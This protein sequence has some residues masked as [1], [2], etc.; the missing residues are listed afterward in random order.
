MFVVLMNAHPR[1]LV[2]SAAEDIFT[3]LPAR[4]KEATVVVPCL[5]T[6][7]VFAL[8]ARLRSTDPWRTTDTLQATDGCLRELLEPDGELTPLPPSETFRQ[9]ASC[10]RREGEAAA[11]AASAS[12]VAIKLRMCGGCGLV[13]YCD[14]GCQRRHWP[15]HKLVCRKSS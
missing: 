14:S 6:L 3:H 1:E 13:P 10:G 9:C 15:Q 8:A 11:G 2:A 5:P 7:D 12:E 4:I